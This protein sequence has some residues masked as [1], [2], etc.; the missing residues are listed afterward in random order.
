MQLY[1]SNKA[2]LILIKA[3]LHLLFFQKGETV[4]RIREEV[5]WS[6]FQSF[7]ATT[8]NNLCI[9]LHVFTLCLESNAICS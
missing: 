8:L 6:V 9:Y 1:F 2:H 4:K 7:E 3:V 5:Q